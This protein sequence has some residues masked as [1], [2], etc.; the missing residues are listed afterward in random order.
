MRVLADNRQ[1]RKDT[2]RILLIERAQEILEDRHVR[3]LVTK[4]TGAPTKQFEKS[5]EGVE[6]PVGSISITDEPGGDVLAAVPFGQCERP[7]GREPTLEVEVALRDRRA[8]VLPLG[9]HYCTSV[10]RR[11]ARN[12]PVSST[13]K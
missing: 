5:L 13:A 9:P 7:S 10:T 11:V 1:G 3:S 2:G 6:L 4:Q 12:S 8:L